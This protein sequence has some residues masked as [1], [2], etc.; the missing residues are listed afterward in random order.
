MTLFKIEELSGS[1]IKSGRFQDAIEVFNKE[2]MEAMYEGVISTSELLGPGGIISR[3]NHIL[4]NPSNLDAVNKLGDD[5]IYIAIRIPNYVKK[6][7]APFTTD[8]TKLFF[9]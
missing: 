6:H 4:L 8:N 2:L 1:L 3:F 9:D 5:M 7:D